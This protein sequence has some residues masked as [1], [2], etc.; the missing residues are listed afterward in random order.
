MSRRTLEIAITV[1][2]MLVFISGC[3]DESD[4][5]DEV[6]PTD[7]AGISADGG[8]GTDTVGCDLEP[9][10]I[11]PPPSPED[12]SDALLPFSQP[13]REKLLTL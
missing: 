6:N 13:P 5:D 10:T 2:T 1:F 11:N 8:L 3:V 7:D 9:F 12:L 4:T